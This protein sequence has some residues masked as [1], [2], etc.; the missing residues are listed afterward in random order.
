ME[1][2]TCEACGEPYTPS[3]RANAKTTCSE[4]CRLWL[5]RNPGRRRPRPQSRCSRCDGP[6]PTGR[7]RYCSDVCMTRP[8][9]LDKTE[10]DCV[11]CGSSFIPLAANQKCCPPSAAEREA[12]R[13][14]GAIQARSSCA[15]AYTNALHRGTLDD[16]LARNRRPGDPFDCATCGRAC[17]PGENVAAHA[18]KFCDRACLKVWHKPLEEAAAQRR[19][20]RRRAGRKL[21][22]AAH[23]MGTRRRR[24][25]Q[26]ICPICESPSSTVRDDRRSSARCRVERRASAEE[27]AD[28]AER[29]TAPI[30]IGAALDAM[31]WRTRWSTSPACSNA[32]ATAAES[33]DGSRSEQQRCRT[34]ERRRWTT[35]C[36]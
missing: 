24:W 19:A 22:R 16:L 18:T 36:R 3:K 29:S 12:A 33:A 13:A 30:R 34:Q 35:W 1:E 10:R 26:A 17:V 20:R 4:G 7:R 23:G 25:V 5:I 31:A 14:R 28:A 32:T 9:R 15:R 11:V 21:E 6:L 27:F 2:R 8:S